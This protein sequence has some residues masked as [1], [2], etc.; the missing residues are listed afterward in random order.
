[1]ATEVGSIPMMPNGP[2]DPEKVA[3]DPAPRIDQVKLEDET[4]QITVPPPSDAQ[5]ANASSGETKP[6]AGATPAPDAPKILNLPRTAS[7]GLIKTPLAEP[8]ETSQPSPKLALTTEQETKYASLLKNVSAWT[9]IPE[10]SARGSKTTP[11]T[12]SERMFLTR[13]CLLR[14]LRATNWNVAQSET[15]LRNTLVW[16]REY[17]LEKHTKEYISIE[18]ATGKQVILGWDIQGRTCQ[19]LRPSKQNTERSDRQIQH[20][21]FMLERAIDLMPPGQETL[22]LLINFAETKSGQGATLSQ[23]KQ[24]LNI[25][26]NH[27]PERLG[28][29][30]VT[31]VPFYIW[32]FFKL[33]TPFI[34][35]LTREKIKFNEDMG[36]HVPREQLLKE[37][38]GLVEFEYDHEVYWPALN[39]LCESKRS[40]FRSRWEEGGRRIGEY[41]AYLKGAGEK[42]LAE[43]EKEAE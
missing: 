4:A 8:L 27:Y 20:L 14:Y 5:A 7:D 15:R 25:L 33:I 11:L 29:A 38:G 30:L 3:T 26:Q 24:T 42:S 37:S 28:R 10:T 16:R 13:E 18:N 43:R 9:E 22:A 23:G 40:E 6:E 34:D 35:P 32:G 39:D 17:G 31:N 12:D 21:V 41:E 36:L 2:T 1:M 19:Y